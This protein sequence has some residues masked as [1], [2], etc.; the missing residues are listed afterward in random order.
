MAAADRTDAA[1]MPPFQESY[2]VLQPDGTY[3][4]STYREGLIVAILSLGS[5]TGALIG[6]PWADLLGRVRRTLCLRVLT[7]SAAPSSRHPV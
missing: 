1:V 5:L 4:F 2:G 3:G 6:V 7:V